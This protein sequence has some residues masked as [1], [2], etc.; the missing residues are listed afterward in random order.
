M[1][2]ESI[3]SGGGNPRM[4]LDEGKGAFQKLDVLSRENGIRVVCRNASQESV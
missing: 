4:I 2:P 3:M 1:P